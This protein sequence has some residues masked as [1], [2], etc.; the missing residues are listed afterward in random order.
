MAFNPKITDIQPSDS[1]EKTK[2]YQ[3]VVTLTDKSKY[4]LFLS[5]N[6][7][8]SL[9]SANRLLNIPCPMCRKD[10]YC[11]CMDKHLPQLESEFL[12]KLGEQA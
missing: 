5:K 11:K 3:Y 9:N 1:N 8:W 4:R 12:S 10:Y 6:P 7:D 2:L